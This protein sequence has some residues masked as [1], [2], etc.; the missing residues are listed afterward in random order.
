M[1]TAIVDI[2]QVRAKK[3]WH[4][5]PYSL[6]VQS[7]MV[8]L[9]NSSFP[10]Y[11]LGELVTI[12]RGY[13]IKSQATEGIP[14]VTSGNLTDTGI[15]LTDVGTFITPEEHQKLSA[16]Q[17][18]KG[19]IVIS[20]A[21]RLS[22]V[23][24]YQSDEPANLNANLA[25]LTVIGDIDIA[26]LVSYLNSDI[27]QAL[28]HLQA[29]GST[30]P[31]LRISDLAKLPVI[32]PPLVIQKQIASQAQELINQADEFAR[33]AEKNRADARNLFEKLR[34]GELK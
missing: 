7:V 10:I 26:Y 12:S 27:G 29:T 30:Q 21:G 32:V 17:L 28:I 9:G 5:P 18:R 3:V 22:K 1:E 23:A 11:P 14:I 31:F 25:M 20:L 16:T 2:A 4:F 34:K 33:S 15:D 19:N 8:Q 24:V 6:A 13:T